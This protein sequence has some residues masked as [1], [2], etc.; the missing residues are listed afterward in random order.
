ML[1]LTALIVPLHAARLPAALMMGLLAAGIVMSAVRRAGDAHR[2]VYPH[3]G[4][5]TRARPFHGA[6]A[7]KE[8]GNLKHENR[9]QRR[10]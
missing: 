2:P 6:P 4:N 5:W 10:S 9:L 3:T 1:A 8:A 7:H